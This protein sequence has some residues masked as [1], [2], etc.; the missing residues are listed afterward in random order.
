MFL[1]KKEKIKNNQGQEE[2]KGIYQLHK[3]SWC[4]SPNSFA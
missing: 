3:G 1:F 2:K 4:L